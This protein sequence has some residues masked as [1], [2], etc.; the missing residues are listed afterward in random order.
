MARCSK[1]DKEIR[2]IKVKGSKSLIV[3][4]NSVYFLPDDNG[5]V[6]VMTNG[7]MRTGQ[8]AFDGIK[9]FTLH[10]CGVL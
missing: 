7:K 9:G 2:F 3:N 10:D 6:Y 8:P 4:S 1:C 5:R